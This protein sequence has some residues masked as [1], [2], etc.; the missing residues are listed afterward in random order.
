MPTLPNVLAQHNWL[1]VSELDAIKKLSPEERIK[2]AWKEKFDD[3]EVSEDDK[4]EFY[5]Q[6]RKIY[7]GDTIFKALKGKF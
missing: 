1:F 5:H 7:E 3:N 6:A 2:R 4:F